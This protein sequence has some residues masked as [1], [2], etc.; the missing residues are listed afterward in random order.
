VTLKEY[1][2]NYM[3]NETQSFEYCQDVIRSFEKLARGMIADL[4]TGIEKGSL[5]QILS[6]M[7]SIE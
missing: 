7:L 2:V 6:A 3:R 1:A 4:P 5:E